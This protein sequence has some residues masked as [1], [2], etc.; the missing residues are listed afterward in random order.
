MVQYFN[1]TMFHT[2]TQHLTQWHNMSHRDTICVSTVA[3]CTQNTWHSGKIF[4]TGTQY[5]TAQWLN[6]SHTDTIF[7]AVEQYFPQGHNMWQHSGSMYHTG[8][9]Y[10]TQR[11]RSC[12][13]S[14]ALWTFKPTTQRQTYTF[15][16][17]LCVTNGALNHR[18]L[19]HN[20]WGVFVFK[21]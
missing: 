3:Q 14:P 19:L 5:V 10:L 1:G 18:I 2:G 8:T 9:Q 21:Q 6:V 12:F 17:K 11:Q 20:F 13:W 15:C 4:F 16:F 7:D